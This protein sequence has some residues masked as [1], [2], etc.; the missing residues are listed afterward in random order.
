MKRLQQELTRRNSTVPVI[1]VTGHGDVPLAV[2]AMRAGAFDFLEKPYD[3]DVLLDSIRRAL[4]QGRKTQ[5]SQT[6]SRAAA[7]LKEASALVD[8]PTRL[9]CLA[10]GLSILML[11]IR[12]ASL[13]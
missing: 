2:T 4:A 8:A 13:W 5:E 6:E 7:A 9:V 1:V 3:D 10:L 11:A 12:I